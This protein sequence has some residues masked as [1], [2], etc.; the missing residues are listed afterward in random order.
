MKLIKKYR[1]NITSIICLTLLLVWSLCSSLDKEGNIVLAEES[2]S[3]SVTIRNEIEDEVMVPVSGIEVNLCQVALEDG[4]G[5]YNLT[6]NFAD[7][8]IVI[9]E[10][11]NN[12]DKAKEL[13]QYIKDNDISH[14]T[15]Y[16]NNSGKTGF[17]D[18]AKGVY[19]VFGN[20]H[21][22]VSY[23]PFVIVLPA[24][25]DG[26][27]VYHVETLPKTTDQ[28]T[29]GEEVYK[30]IDVT[31]IWD[32]NQDQ[33]GKRPSAVTVML[34]RSGV[35]YKRVTL[36]SSNGWTHTFGQ[37]PASGTYTVRET[38]VSGYTASYSGNETN[39]YVI[40]NK[41]HTGGGGIAPSPNTGT[42]S[43]SKV[44]VDSDNAEGSRPDSITVQ[45][46]KDDVVSQTATLNEN[47]QWQY[48]FKGLPTTSTYTVKEITP[49]NYSAEYTGSMEE[50]YVITN[51]YT[52]GTTDPGDPPNPDK[53]V[54]PK[55]TKISVKKVWNDN[56][57]AAGKRPTKI[58]VKLIA[59]NS[60]YDKVTLNNDNNWKATFKNLPANLTYTILEEAV[61][62]YTASYSG[63]SSEGYT[64]TNKYTPGT[65]DPGVPPESTKPQKSDDNYTKPDE[66]DPNASASTPVE[67]MI[68]QTGFIM[69]PIYL[70]VLLGVILILL[71]SI[72]LRKE[73]KKA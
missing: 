6:D 59:D 44:W 57:D 29:G 3:L 52:K 22:S 27:E 51:R 53:P 42:V 32:D 7:S 66:T 31:K 62:D 65:T 16:T 33:A 41:Y 55:T 54:T 4:N 69:W 56:D 18:L 71:G 12:A 10:I 48:T 2:C 50:G 58:K 13:A 46:I 39:G 23:N 19:V 17:Y 60:V 11:T 25:V 8:G 40:T 14:T 28:P 30:S 37:L 15:Q 5:Q 9:S 26:S 20:D 36:N 35:E 73:R 1:K 34:Y 24:L 63:S 45:L 38:S 49:T 68:P 43:V 70:L 67:P 72:D 61:T 47:N 21:Q 64:V